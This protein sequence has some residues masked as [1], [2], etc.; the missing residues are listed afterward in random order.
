MANDIFDQGK[1][2]MV[3]GLAWLTDD[4]KVLLIDTGSHSI[5]LSADRHHDDITPAAII[6]TSANMTTKTIADGILDAADFTFTAVSGASVEAMIVY[7]DTGVSATSPLL[8]LID[9][10]TGLPLT[11][12]GGDISVVWDAG[13]NKIMAL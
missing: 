5:S 12:T 13:A 9:T 8:L 3:A 1:Q 10:A 11:P 4:I 7:K 2:E 6:A